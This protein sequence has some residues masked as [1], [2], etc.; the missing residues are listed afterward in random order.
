[1]T[2]G[3]TGLSIWVF[4][5][6]VLALLKKI[7]DQDIWFDL[8]LG[9]EIFATG[10]IP[11]G[12][13]YLY[14][15]LGQP[16]TWPEWGFGLLYY[17]VYAA[18]GFWGMSILK[19]LMG[20]A[21]LVAFY[22]AAL[23]GRCVGPAAILTLCALLWLVDHRAVYRP[24]MVLYLSLGC[25]VYLL[26]RY[27]ADRR[28]RWLL[29][30]PLLGF[31]LAQFHPSVIFLLAVLG[32]YVAQGLWEAFRT[33][34]PGDVV[35]TVWPLAAALCAT[36]LAAAFNPYGIE[37]ILL[38]F[39]YAQSTDLLENIAEYRPALSTN[40]RWH[41]LAIGALGTWAVI[42]RRPRRPV[43]LLCLALFGYLGVR[44]VRNVALLGLMM[45]V[46]VTRALDESLRRVG[47]VA[48]SS[49]RRVMWSVAGA[50]AA[51]TVLAFVLGPNWGA[52]VE[53]NGVPDRAVRVLEV[54]E[55]PGRIFNYYETGGY[56][57]WRLYDQYRVFIDGRR[58]TNDVANATHNAVFFDVDPDWEQ[59]LHKYRVN[60]IVT[61]ATTS[62]SGQLV[63]LVAF[64]DSREDWILVS[65]EPWFY[66]YLRTEAL[67]G[68]EDFQL[69]DQDEIWRTV[70]READ[71]TLKAYPGRSTP[72]LMTKGIAAFKL[73]RFDD[74]AAWIGTYAQRRPSDREAVHLAA[75]LEAA[76][77]GDP[78]ARERIEALYREGRNER[79][80]VDW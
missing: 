32:F 49:G 4:C 5:L 25:E 59:V 26:E 38:P 6:L 37:Q 21:M 33:R 44:Y 58:Y 29:P 22:R 16:T 12:E 24:E 7:T 77:R 66:L 60:A 40:Y 13:F 75:E 19:A 18:F 76:V 42:G 67:A 30:L 2:L 48:R 31:L 50:C 43:D 53:Q 34:G 15:L 52:G 65:V 74:A 14:S 41:L 46:P 57:A 1:M 70:I 64:L 45:Y 71:A 79:R 51:G 55:P 73:G 63:P 62:I 36:V 3:R 8:V 20:G 72:A 68:H 54:L 39:A 9:R 28:R 47:A 35:D 78:G 80:R 23:V 69:P 17:A 61:R 10:Y 27:L 11:P 56:L